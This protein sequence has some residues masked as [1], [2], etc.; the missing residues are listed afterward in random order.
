M[1]VPHSITKAPFL[2]HAWINYFHSCQ[3]SI[4]IDNNDKFIRKEISK[5]KN[6]FHLVLCSSSLF[7]MHWI[8]DILLTWHFETKEHIRLFF[9]LYDHEEKKKSFFHLSISSITYLSYTFISFF[10]GIT[11]SSLSQENR[12]PYLSSK[13][14]FC[15]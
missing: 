12:F 13:A 4:T 2:A 14:K 15:F 10:L 8:H 11:I 7:H 6:G 9:K 3:C 1:H 5:T